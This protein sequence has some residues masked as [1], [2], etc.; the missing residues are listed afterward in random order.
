[1]KSLQY[2]LTKIG[3][4]KFIIL[5]ISI[6]LFLAKPQTFTADHLVII[7]SIFI[8]AN[9]TQKVLGGKK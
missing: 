1:M 2:Y 8:G 6:S 4:R 5:L 3:S 9:T 7:M